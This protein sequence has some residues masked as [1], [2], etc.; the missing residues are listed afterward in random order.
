[1]F[2]KLIIVFCNVKSR[3]VILTLKSFFEEK[4]CF[5]TFVIIVYRLNQVIM[6][7]KTKHYS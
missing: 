3:I 7:H 1:M 2:L 5:M 4:T 6:T